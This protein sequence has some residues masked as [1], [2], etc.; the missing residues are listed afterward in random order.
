[1]DRVDDDL[2]MTEEQCAV[3][4]PDRSRSTPTL[5]APLLGRPANSGVI[6][7]PSHTK[8][9][10]AMMAACVRNLDRTILAHEQEMPPL[11]LG[12]LVTSE[13]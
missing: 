2:S 1:M 8:A 7:K 13:M 9:T 10:E 6:M 11:L 3:R 5:E 4:I 12:V